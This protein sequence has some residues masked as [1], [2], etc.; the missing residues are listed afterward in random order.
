MKNLLKKI[1]PKSCLFFYH[2]LLAI[3]AAYAYN[4]PSRKMVVIGVTGTNGKTT[5]CNM[6]AKILEE[7]GYKV[8][9]TTTANFKIGE[10]EWINAT[11]QTMQGRFKLQKLLHRMAEA[12]CKY[13]IIET[14]SEGIAQS[15]H[16]GISYDVAVFTNLT[17]EHIESHGSFEKYKE[18][19]GK[20]FKSLKQKNARTEKKENKKVSIVNLDDPKDRKSV[21]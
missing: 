13:A 10:K 19:K 11:K 3:L 14:S 21:V 9:L 18:A 15:R 6:I 8:G 1:I 4:F 5:V 17:P 12:G 7:A 16:W 20:L 2:K